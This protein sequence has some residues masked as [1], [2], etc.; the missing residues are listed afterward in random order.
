MTTIE[1]L[2][3]GL[4][5]PEAAERFYQQFTERHPAAAARLNRNDSLRLDVLTLASFSP[6]LAA[7]MLQN[8]EYVSWLGRKRADSGVR[9]KEEMLESLAR[10][11]LTNSQ[12]ETH[13]QLARFRRREL[14]RIFLRD[15]RGLATI[16]EITEEI[17]SLADAVLEHA[18][19]LAHQELNNRYGNPLAT[20]EKGRSGN[21]DFCIVSLGK[22]GSK[23][24]NYASDID[25][26]FI[27]SDEGTTAGGGTRAAVSNREYFAKLAEAVVDLVGRQR[28]EGAAYRVDLR[29][30][31]HGRVGPLAMSLAEI[32]RYYQMEAALWER[33]VL[34][35]CRPSAGDEALFKRFF[36][37]VQSTVFSPD[38]KI[39]SAL[40]N[41]RRSKQ[42]I[43]LAQIGKNG[44]DVK[45]GRGGIREIEFI[46]QALQLAHGGRDRWLRSPHTLISLSRLADREFI[47][48]SELAKLFEGYDFFRRAEHLLQMENGLQ[49]HTVPD[50]KAKRKLLAAKMGF[51]ALN[52]FDS[53][54]K[55]HAENVSQ[56]FAR[57]FGSESTKALNKKGGDYRH[58][59]ENPRLGRHSNRPQIENHG[60]DASLVRTIEVSRKAAEMLAAAPHLGRSLTAIAPG[61]YY[62]FLMETI[63]TADDFGGRLAALRRAWAS[64][65]LAVINED[66]NGELTLDDVKR[67]Q[68]LLAEASMAAGL[69]I[70]KKELEHKHHLT[71]DELPIAILGLGKLGGGAMDYDSD[72]DI[73]IAYAEKDNP[74][75]L[76]GT[77]TKRGSITSGEFYAQLIEIFVNSLSALT[78]NGSLY[79]VDLRLRPF[80]KDGPLAIERIAFTEYV[81][82]KAAIWELLAFVKLRAA[83]GKFELAKQIETEVREIV[84]RR[85]HRI[86]P[87][88]L[89]A[90]TLSIRNR[91]ERQMSP[92]KKRREID[93]KYG[94]GGML[95]IYFATR[96][97]QLRHNIPDSEASRTTASTLGLLLQRGAVSHR[98]FEIFI[99]GHHFLSRL[100][101][102]LRLT[103]GRRAR[104]RASDDSA[105]SRLAALLG[106]GSGHQ[107]LTEL[108]HH[109]NEIRRVFD[110]ILK[111][112]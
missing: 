72:L 97:L 12:V 111:R 84:H 1:T 102:I 65:I 79:R 96:F 54:L 69:F 11:S 26:L 48:E 19:R 32:T 86:A 95:D 27:Y 56:I 64:A 36:T 18:L 7:A 98:Q 15:V 29:L 39:E 91:L 9:S 77:S 103:V 46:A 62:P 10:Y 108:E 58:F 25:L 71:I 92:E 67:R 38:E 23:E 47:S 82:S 100:D 89:A 105:A 52:D 6:L 4:P 2:L 31:P 57:I 73:V 110:E 20:D 106:L 24:L 17:S 68:T 22:L 70:A 60:V 8:P 44:Y 74:P 109:R 104:I 107:L 66:V 75:F 42:K 63:E 41:V 90:E 85:A 101:H 21:A 76:Q 33:Q 49:T 80:G 78:R 3:K 55:N 88:L 30:R 59:A 35:R 53:E 5:D 13:V 81:E 28:G 112:E 93:I 83:G 37:K 16:A 51:A 50:D 34:I 45:L 40:E 43:D 99:A 61:D 14:M 94:I 87:R